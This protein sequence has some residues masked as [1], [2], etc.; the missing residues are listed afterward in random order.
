MRAPTS[1]ERQLVG[2]ATAIGLHNLT[3]F[4]P[5]S[6]AQ[7]AAVAATLSYAVAG[8]WAR[9]RLAMSMSISI[10]CS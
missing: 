8:V 6:I 1:E 2:V 5:R 4:N 10:A 3:N 9:K 7:L